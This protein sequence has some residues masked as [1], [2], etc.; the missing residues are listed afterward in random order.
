MAMQR[1]AAL[2]QSVTVHMGKPEEAAE[3]ITV[4][5]PEY[6]KNTASAEIAPTLPEQTIRR[7]VSLLLQF[8]LNRIGGRFYRGRG[9]AFDIT[10]LPQ[11]DRKFNKHGRT[12]QN[13]NQIVEEVLNGMVSVPLYGT[14]RGEGGGAPAAANAQAYPGYPLE[15]GSSGPPVQTVQ[16]E[17]NRVAENY[18]AIPKIPEADGNFG[19]DTAAAVRRF[20]EISGLALDG[21]VGRDTWHKL[22]HIYNGIRRLSGLIYEG[23]R[24]GETGKPLTAELKEGASGSDVGEAQYHINVVAYFYPEVPSVALDQYYGPKTETAVKAFQKLSY[25]VEDGVVGQNTWYSMGSSCGNIMGCV[26]GCLSEGY[27]K[28][29]AADY[30]GYTLSAG[31]ENGDVARLQQYLIGISQYYGTI[32]LIEKTGVFDEA[33][34]AAVAALQEQN[35]IAPSGT[36]DEATWNMIAWRY[37]TR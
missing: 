8:A 12:Y 16:L 25:L 7:R 18:P 14:G 21:I 9:Y 10:G 15:E 34:A 19:K 17:L 6:L 23:K 30:P 35:G 33:T 20:Q 5:F 26:S 13:V 29:C 2:P 11:Y 1:W 27:I 24:L 37:D 36:V 4:P 31:M 32:P 3:E 22:R 28:N